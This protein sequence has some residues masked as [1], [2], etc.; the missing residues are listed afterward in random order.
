LGKITQENGFINSEI[1][2]IRQKGNAIREL[3]IKTFGVY[4]KSP[5]FESEDSPLRHLI[6]C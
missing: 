3:D 6:C 4:N 2:I 1:A 5:N